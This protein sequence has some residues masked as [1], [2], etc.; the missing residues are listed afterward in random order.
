MPYTGPGGTHMQ[1]RGCAYQFSN[2]GAISGNFLAKKGVI[3][4]QIKKEVIGC[5]TAQNLGNFTLFFFWNFRCSLQNLMSSPEILIEKSKNLWSL[6]VKLWGGGQLVTNW[7][8]KGSLLTG[9]WFILPNG[10]PPAYIRLPNY[11]FTVLSLTVCLTSGH[12][13]SSDMK[14]AGLVPWECTSPICWTSKWLLNSITLPIG[15]NKSKKLNTANSAS[16]Q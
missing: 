3:G 16:T 14:P 8:R 4:W 9:A 1:V 13:Y 12:F 10:A 2:E 6:G 11:H 7:C 5:E 15:P